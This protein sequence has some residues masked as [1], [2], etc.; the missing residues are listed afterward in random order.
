MKMRT[1]HIV[2]LSLQAVQILQI[3]H[4]ITGHSELLFPGERNHSK[5][6]SNNTILKALERLGYKGRMT[7]HGFRGLASTVL[8]EQ[9]F[10]HAHI[11][12]QLA[13]R[14]RDAV[15]AAYNHA[16]YLKQR[17]KMMQWWAGYL[18]QQVSGNVLKLRV[19]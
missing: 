8:H 1:E 9:G 2:P 13:H 18:D 10:D 5:Q 17:S 12:L 19:G 15:S 3:L 4:G 14:E 11:E 7:G 6:M 16:L